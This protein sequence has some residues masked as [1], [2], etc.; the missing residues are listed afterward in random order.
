MQDN[1]HTHHGECARRFRNPQVV[2]DRHT[3]PANIR[4]IEHHEL[5]AGGNTHFVGFKWRHLSV[6]PDYVSGRIYNR[7]RVVDALAH[8]LIHRPRDEPELVL[9]RHGTKHFFR[10]SRHGLGR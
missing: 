1:L 6:P 10:W 5:V 8:A 2:A 3:K 7:C 9:L 4:Y